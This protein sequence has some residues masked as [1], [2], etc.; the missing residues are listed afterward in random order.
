MVRDVREEKDLREGKKKGKV[1]EKKMDNRF[2]KLT[3]F[4]FSCQSVTDNGSII[5]ARH[6]SFHP[7]QLLISL[8]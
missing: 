4:F 7:H 3:I 6:Y 8:S 2:N 1:R 5:E